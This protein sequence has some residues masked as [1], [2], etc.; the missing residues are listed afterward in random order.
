MKKQVLSKRQHTN[1]EMD[2]NEPPDKK[3]GRQL[4]LVEE[5]DKL[6][7]FICVRCS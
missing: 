2:V 7:A 3:R 5:V 6:S 1:K 4:M